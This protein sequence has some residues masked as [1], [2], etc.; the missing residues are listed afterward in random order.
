MHHCSQ[1]NVRHHASF[2]PY[3]P[4]VAIDRFHRHLPF[5][6]ALKS[7]P[8][9]LKPLVSNDKW[10]NATKA[11]HLDLSGQTPLSMQVA[12]TLIR[13]LAFRRIPTTVSRISRFLLLPYSYL[14]NGYRATLP[15]SS[16]LCPLSRLTLPHIFSTSVLDTGP[17]SF[18]RR[19]GLSPT[20]T[21]IR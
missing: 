12:S 18:L 21:L 20:G 9:P 4:S 10:I 17:P 8:P 5:L 11:R 6:S 3:P 19:V 1:H 13:N 7:P 2:L 14:A 16:T 15:C